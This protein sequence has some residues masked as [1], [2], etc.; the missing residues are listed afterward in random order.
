MMR[1]TTLLAIGLALAAS[2]RADVS[3]WSPGR[4][5][6]DF[7]GDGMSDVVLLDAA[8]GVLAIWLLDALG[9]KAGGGFPFPAGFELRGVGK[10]DDDAKDDLVLFDPVTRDVHLWFMDGLNLASHLPI[11]N[12][13]PLEPVLVDRFDHL[14]DGADLLLVDPVTGEVGI[15]RLDAGFFVG[16]GLVGWL[17]VGWGIVASGDF[18]S[19]PD[20]DADLLVTDEIDWSRGERW[21]VESGALAAQLPTGGLSLAPRGDY[22]PAASPLDGPA[23]DKITYG[24]LWFDELHETMRSRVLVEPLDFGFNGSGALF[25]V[26]LEPVELR[27]V[28]KF[29]GDAAPDALWQTA[30]AGHVVAW[31]LAPDDSAFLGGPLYTEDASFEVVNLGRGPFGRPYA[32]SDFDGD[33]TSDVLVL[34]P[35]G[36]ELE[37][38]LVGPGASI[39]ER[40]TLALPAGHEVRGVAR[41]SADHRA[42]VVLFETATSQVRVWVMN[43]LVVKRTIELGSS[44]GA[45]P[46]FFPRV[47]G[48]DDR[49]DDMIL[50]DPAS[51]TLADWWIRD[52]AVANARIWG[53]TTFGW[54]PVAVSIGLARHLDNT[55]VILR[56]EQAPGE[57]LTWRGPGIAG[58][59]GRRDR[60]ADGNLRSAIYFI[61]HYQPPDVPVNV[62]WQAGGGGIPNVSWWLEGVPGGP[63]QRSLSTSHR[64]EPLF[65]GDYDGDGDL[66]LVAQDPADGDVLL[67]FIDG[68][69]VVDS[70]V[71]AEGSSDPE[72]RVV[73]HGEALPTGGP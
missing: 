3:D 39:R 19:T 37:V 71:L 4:A 49:E 23:V 55:Y 12:S 58:T 6:A 34:D 25:A 66:D 15:W 24:F 31:S 64:G 70:V 30:D 29:V 1:L 32:P 41:I 33:G 45:V 10:F 16:G 67:W 2:S 44:G 52:E 69:V 47:E 8:N 21:I 17:P 7:D 60:S 51:K 54:E 46:L 14:G 72:L 11:G 13:G 61:G 57:E 26:D 68:T 27:S 28:G 53:E 43:G 9:I 20:G 36:R 40:A 22:V 5:P 35:D 56:S 18:D 42:D 50:W 59:L 63:V 48:S 38:W 65:A 73:N 62:T